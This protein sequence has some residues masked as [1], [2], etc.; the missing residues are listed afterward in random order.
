MGC[1]LISA[2]EN[3]TPWCTCSFSGAVFRSA[4]GSQVYI[5]QPNVLHT[6]SGMDSNSSPT[7]RVKVDTLKMNKCLI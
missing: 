1:G 7:G 3:K 6:G 2:D 5:P 4:V